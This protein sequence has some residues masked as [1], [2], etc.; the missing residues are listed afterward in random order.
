MVAH[1]EAFLVHSEGFSI[2]PTL[3]REMLFD[4]F[5]IDSP[6]GKILP[7]KHAWWRKHKYHRWRLW[8]STAWMKFFATTLKA[9]KVEAPRW[10]DPESQL[11]CQ[12]DKRRPHETTSTP[13][14]AD[15]IWFSLED[16]QRQRLSQVFL[17]AL[18]QNFGLRERLWHSNHHPGKAK[19][20]GGGN[21]DDWTENKAS[22]PEALEKPLEVQHHSQTKPEDFSHRFAE[23][24][25]W[26]IERPRVNQKAPD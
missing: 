26:Q 16:F 23:C 2:D 12:F 3:S 4:D 11:H 1:L 7:S 5:E 25:E 13:F 22:H 21:S 19:S 9:A 17:F 20:C 15:G 6:A 18:F 8:F 24:R 14:P 10:R